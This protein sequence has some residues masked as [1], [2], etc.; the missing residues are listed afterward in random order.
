MRK[1]MDEIFNL[2]DEG[3]EDLVRDINETVNYAIDAAMRTGLK[4][5][6][7]NVKISIRLEVNNDGIIC[8]LIQCKTGVKMGVTVEMKKRNMESPL[9]F[10]KEDGRFWRAVR[11]AEQTRIEGA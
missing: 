3:Y 7:A 6:A 11:L 4:E 8:P 1:P 10:F 9:G 2:M 5:A